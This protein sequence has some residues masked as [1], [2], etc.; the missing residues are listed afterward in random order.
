MKFQITQFKLNAF[1]FGVFCIVVYKGLIAAVWT[2]VIPANEAFWLAIG[3]P[4]GAIAAGLSGF[5]TEAPSN[6][7][8]KPLND[9]LEA[10]KNKN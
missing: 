2:G 10:L 8:E 3:V 9:A 4:I 5:T 7:L 1:I 6:P